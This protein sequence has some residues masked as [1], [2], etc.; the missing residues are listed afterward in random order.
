MIRNLK[1]INIIVLCV[2]LFA[3]IS[4]G[5][6]D[7]KRYKIGVAQCS[8]DYWREKTNQDLQM[9]LLNHPNVQLDIRN[10]DND[11]RR[12]QEDVRYF[13]NNSYDLIIL[14]PNES[15]PLVDVVKEAKAK[16]IPVVT[17]DR[18][19]NS[20]DFTA[21][22][23]VDNYALGKGVVKYAKT[24]GNK[25]LKIIEIRGPESASPAQLRHEGFMDGVKENPNM[26]VVASVFGEWDYARAEVLTDS[27][28]R[29]HPEVNLLY[30]HTDHMALG[31][32]EALRKNGRD[33]VAVI[34]IDGFPHQGIKGVSDGKLTAT[35]LYPTEGQRL[36]RIALAVLNGEPYER[37]TRVSPLSPIDS[38][39]AD[40][41]LAQDT[42]LNEETAKITL[43]N[44][45]ID[46]QLV[47]YSSQK[48]LLWAFVA[49]AL[50]LGDW[51]SYY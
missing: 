13:I 26:E 42:L 16:G 29:I 44:N 5:R 3:L 39:N 50:L 25:P 33:D 34:G 8:G 6:D 14:A 32:S 11:S 19:I 45:K 41:L 24:L 12:Q 35:F 7:E 21:H 4:C 27:L 1:I 17:F 22:M 47:R 43:L 37:V 38:S 10:A 23:E 2:S 51:Y 40:I 15:E 28:L 49:I 46:Q 9:E 18:R 36:L 48:I 31:A 20:D 30:A